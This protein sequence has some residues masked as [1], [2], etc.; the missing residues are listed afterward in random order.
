MSNKASHITYVEDAEED[1]G[2]S[3]E[4]N[5]A[6]RRYAFSEAPSSPYKERPNTGKSRAD[7]RTS[8]RRSDSSSPTS[9]TDSDSTP[10]SS[11]RERDTRR[12]YEQQQREKDRRRKER[13]QKDAAEQAQRKA[14]VE[15][16]PVKE[17]EAKMVKKR[18]ASMSQSKT[19]PIL[20]QQYR[21]GHVEDPS[22]YGVQQQSARPRALTGQSASYYSG[23]PVATPPI[24]HAGWHQAHQPQSPFGMGSFPP[25]PFSAGSPSV[26]GVPPSHAPAPSYFDN[27]MSAQQQRAHLKNRFERPERPNSVIGYREAAPSTFGFDDYE[28][29]PSG[30]QRVAR[31]PSRTKKQNDEDRKKMPPPEFIP[32]PK[33]ALPPASSFRPPPPPPQQSTPRQKSR[34]P[35]TRRGVGFADQR[36]FDD[37]DFESHEELFTDASPESFDRRT[38]LAR[39]RRGSVTYEH[40]GMDIMPA[41]RRS[42]R[43]SFYGDRDRALGTGGVSLE[44]DKYMDALKYQD[45]VNGGPSVPLTA[46]TLRKAS[47]RGT[48]ASSRSTRSSGSH[49]DSEYK[50]SN[51]TGIT[52]SSTA[53]TD[54]VTIK[55]SGSAVV[56]VQ[57]A[58]IQCNDGGE[59]TFSSRGGDGSSRFGSDRASTV[60]QLEDSRSRV[61]RKALP[62][63]ARAPSQADSQSRGYTPSHAPYDPAFSADD[64]I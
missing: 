33:S 64:Y 34:P 48:G 6:T 18:P 36:G 41:G 63:R 30:R 16:R 14:K 1:S 40:H 37:E 12:E 61:E 57:G 2:S 26:V 23:Q 28:E 50:R 15:A 9:V 35:A 13:K 53:D 7:K 42:R 10:R 32:R 51:T 43:N 39:A 60:Y 4:G 52:R 25:P 3:I 49:D 55:V 5:P 62:H 17:R 20:Q 8:H 59:I 29:E 24:A 58:E 44:E 56:R 46:E 47:T 45:D 54:N 21:R 22:C 38:A 27:Q 31:R 11:K 19:Q